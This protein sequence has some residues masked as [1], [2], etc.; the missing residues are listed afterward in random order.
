[1]FHQHCSRLDPMVLLSHPRY[2]VPHLPPTI[3]QQ[4]QM[5]ILQSAQ[6]IEI[7]EY[8]IQI[9]RVLQIDL[10]LMI[11]SLVISLRLHYLIIRF[12]CCSI[13]LNIFIVSFTY[14]YNSTMYYLLDTLLLADIL[15]FAVGM[16]HSR[17]Y[18]RCHKKHIHNGISTSFGG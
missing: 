9:C 13:A 12:Y 1:M 6:R 17:V 2:H 15:Y 18:L 14:Y 10:H 7:S 4:T 16:R 8:M 3:F 5:V 11:S